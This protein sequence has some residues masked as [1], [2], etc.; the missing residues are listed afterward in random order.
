MLE[1][2]ARDCGEAACEPTYLTDTATVT[3]TV[4]NVNDN[5]PRSEVECEYS[6]QNTASFQNDVVFH[7]EAS[8]KDG[9]TV[10]FYLA[11][12]NSEYPSFPFS[13]NETTGDILLDKSKIHEVQQLFTFPVELRDS[14]SP[15]LS[16]NISCGMDVVDVND[17]RPVFV[18]PERDRNRALNKVQNHGA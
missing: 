5:R 18:F 8:D 2:E 15:P 16:T 12:D 1:V 10:S 13:I 4:N 3:I 7:L 6:F 14:G 17:Q 9:D 11:S